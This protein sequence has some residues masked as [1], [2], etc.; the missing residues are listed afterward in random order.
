MPSIAS[1]ARTCGQDSTRCHLSW[2]VRSTDGSRVRPTP[3]STPRLTGVRS[4]PQGEVLSTL[5]FCRA[6]DRAAKIRA[7][8]AAAGIE[9]WDDQYIDDGVAECHSV[10]ID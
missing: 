3:M 10:D 9:C 7:L 4:V 8:Q 6:R 5:G 2:P 1:L